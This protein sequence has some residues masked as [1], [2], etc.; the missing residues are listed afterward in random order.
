MLHMPCPML[1]GGADAYAAFVAYVDSI[2]TTQADWTQNLAAFSSNRVRSFKTTAR[3][4][5]GE[6]L[7]GSPW[8]ARFAMNAGVIGRVVQHGLPSQAVFD[9]QIANGRVIFVRTSSGGTADLPSVLRNGFQSEASGSPDSLA[10]WCEEILYFANGQAWRMT[11]RTSGGPTLF[12]V[13]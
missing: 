7:Y 4:L 5:S 12:T 2:A 9:D 6:S 1:L 13:P 10:T 11:P 3:A 8:G